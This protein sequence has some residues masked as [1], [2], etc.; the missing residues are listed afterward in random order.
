MSSIETAEMIQFVCDGCKQ[1]FEFEP[2]PGQLMACWQ[3]LKRQKG[4]TAHL[5][6][7]REME[8]A[9]DG[10]WVERVWEH[11]CP[12]CRYKAGMKILSEPIGKFR[13][14]K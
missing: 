12:K 8:T 5:A 10:V 13:T 9:E 3:W 6:S 2:G 4:W 7:E 14:V 1:S 11:E